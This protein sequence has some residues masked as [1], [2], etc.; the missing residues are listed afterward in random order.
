V[1]RFEIVI[2]LALTACRADVEGWWIGDV[3]GTKATLSLEQAGGV[4]TGEVCMAHACGDIDDGALEEDSLL[5]TFGCSDCALPR[6]T[7]DLFLVEGALEGDA[8]VWDC[9]C[10]RQALLHRCRGPC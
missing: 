1:A 3:E 6:T 2:A 9:S 8:Y 5:L 4:I 7:L 10:R